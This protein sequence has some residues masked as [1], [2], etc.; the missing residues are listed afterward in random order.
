[1]TDRGHP[2][3]VASQYLNFD[4]KRRILVANQPLFD[5]GCYP[6]KSCSIAESLIFRANM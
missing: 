6:K 1:M 4:V 5:I 3:W 2:V